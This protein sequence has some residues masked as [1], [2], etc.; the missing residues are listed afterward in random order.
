MISLSCYCSIFNNAASLSSSMLTKK[1]F[2]WFVD[3][4]LIHNTALFSWQRSHFPSF[5]EVN[6]LNANSYIIRHKALLLG[7]SFWLKLLPQIDALS[8]RLI[9]SVSAISSCISSV[10]SPKSLLRAS[11][12]VSVVSAYDPPTKCT[13]N[14]ST[15]STTSTFADL[16]VNLASLGGDT[17]LGVE[18]LPPIFRISPSL[19]PWFWVQFLSGEDGEGGGDTSIVLFIKL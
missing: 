11:F 8:I 15:I 17:R 16:S 18:I 9:I 19:L 12:E 2:S 7:L 5:V 4:C 6:A 10:L 3:G 1:L 13:E 14:I